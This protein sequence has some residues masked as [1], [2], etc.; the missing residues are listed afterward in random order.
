M[1][2]GGGVGREAEILHL[3]LY[4]HSINWL[5][6]GPLV[7]ADSSNFADFLVFVSVNGKILFIYSSISDTTLMFEH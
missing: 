2:G 7:Q 6:I 5:S 4:N 3:W 1:V